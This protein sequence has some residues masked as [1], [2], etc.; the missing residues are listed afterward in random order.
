MMR[1]A[2]TMPDAQRLKA[3]RLQA[4]IEHQPFLVVIETQIRRGLDA[5][6]FQKRQVQEAA[7]VRGVNH[8]MEEAPHVVGH[9]VRF[10]R[11]ALH[12][13]R[14][15]GFGGFVQ[16][17]R[18]I[19]PGDGI[20]RHAFGRF[21]P[22]QFAAQFVALFLIEA[23]HVIVK[24]RGELNDR[25]HHLLLI[26]QCPTALRGQFRQQR[27]RQRCFRHVPQIERVP[28]VDCAKTSSIAPN[29]SR[30]RPRT[31]IRSR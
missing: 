30:S 29:T 5:V 15:E 3:F 28:R 25:A 4:R 18:V 13:Q 11:A 20:P 23:L 7:R 24:R 27:A 17:V 10:V 26:Q 22:A 31:A 9:E 12:H 16:I 8:L 2:S 14:D 21:A 1:A 6:Y 19:G